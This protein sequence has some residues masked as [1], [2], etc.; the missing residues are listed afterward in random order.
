MRHVFLTLVGVGLLAGLAGLVGCQAQRE[1]LGDNIKE[2]VDSALGTLEV[3]QKEVEIGL[4]DLKTAIR[5]ISKGK[6]EA[7][8]SREQSETAIKDL[9]QEQEKILVALKRVKTW[10][11]KGEEVSVGDKKYDVAG[12]NKLANETAD[13]YTKNEKKLEM[14]KTRLAAQKKTETALAAKQAGYE[15]RVQ[16]LTDKLS[17]I[18]DQMVQAKAIQRASTLAGSGD[19]TLSGKIDQ[20][21][22][23]LTKLD[24]TTRRIMLTEEEK[25]NEATTS[26]SGGSKVDDLINATN[27]SADTM[28]KIDA[29][30][31]KK[32]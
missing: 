21:Q 8:V 2:T 1:V 18:K 17:M 19:E 29:I 24:A 32:N 13:S 11:N 25:F 9:G 3:R 23:N 16:E 20:L 28:A 27:D 15:K 7:Q 5:E 26:D 4:R 22:D 6:F 12:L 31:E 30:L 10:V 14:A